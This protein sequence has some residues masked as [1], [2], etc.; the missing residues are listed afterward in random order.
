MSEDFA[1]WNGSNSGGCGSLGRGRTPA[2]IEVRK[3]LVGVVETAFFNLYENIKS[4]L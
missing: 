1:K 3:L 2:I 4:P